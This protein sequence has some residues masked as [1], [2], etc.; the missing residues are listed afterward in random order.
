MGNNQIP[1]SEK[2]ATLVVDGVEREINYEVYGENAVLVLTDAFEESPAEFIARGR[3]PYRAALVV[4]NGAVAENMSVRPAL[5]G[6][7]TTDTKMENVT[8]KSTT[9]NFNHVIVENSDYEIKNCKFDADTDSDGKRVCDFDGY[10]A[11][12]GAF[13]KT[14]LTIDNCELIS[15]GV[16]KPVLYVDNGA[17]CLM[18]DSSYKCY[19]GKIYSGY[20]NQAGFTK[21]VAPPWVLGITGSARG[22]NLM[23]TLSTLT[24][25]NCDCQA[26]GWGVIS[27]DGGE[28]MALYVVDSSITL[29]MEEDMVDNPFIRRFGSGYGAYAA[30]C[31]EFFYGAEFNV[32]TYAII[33]I[34]GCITLVS[35]NTTVEPK[36]KYFV[37]TGKMG[38]GWDGRPEEIK[39]V[40]WNDEPVFEPIIGKGRPTVVNSDGWGF[41]FHH[42]C[43]I[44]VL[45][46]TIVNTDYS[47]FLIRAVPVKIK[48]DSSTLNPANGVILQIID[49]DDKAVGGFFKP[50][51]FDDDGNLVSAHIGPVFNHE[52]FEHP[53]FP[54][55]DYECV[56]GSSGEKTTAV[57]TNCTL[58]GDI[59]NAS[60]FR[61]VLDGARAQGEELEITLGTGAKLTGVITASS[62]KHI[63]EYG[64]DNNTFTKE[65]YYYLGH[66]TNTPYSNGC[67]NVKVTLSDDAVWTVTSKSI[68]AEL[69][70]GDNASVTAPDGKALAV[71]VDGSKIVLEKGRS[72]TGLIVIDIK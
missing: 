66:V 43:K 4:R 47:T 32:G 8:V 24:I 15:K 5:P 48:V 62:S 30:G 64:R 67:N 50:D 38:I 10:G 35:S 27:T 55:I 19:G 25:V 28:E 9:P 59:Y 12:V 40:F 21:M 26:S 71:T 18:K 58:N 7:E 60:G 49:D 6:G 20:Q 44:N 36:Q 29:N 33:G 37:P 17:N 70:I 41:M 42:D 61:G 51:V 22:I 45:D 57:F 53:G 34:G 63:D 69:N 56:C 1:F 39:D 54:G 65:Q 2:L 52:Y 16:A 68:L 46:G 31:D 23:G 72:Y 3:E 14:K 13:K 11:L